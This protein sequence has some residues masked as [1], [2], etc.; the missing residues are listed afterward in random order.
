MLT[1]VP[2]QAQI[3]TSA[4]CERLSS[5][6]DE[7]ACLRNALDQSR[8]ALQGR[9]ERGE[10]TKP[11]QLKHA[12]ASVARPDLGSEQVADHAV[13][14][15]NKPAARSISA[16][17]VASSSGPQGLL[18][19]KLDNRQVWRQTEQAGIPLSL[20]RD[21]TYPVEIS[22]SGFGGYRMRFQNNGR[23]IVVRRLQ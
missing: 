4:D 18:T 22:G 23:V 13:H 19:L 14:P 20:R 12:A 9:K 8:A 1:G 3:A 2:G 5:Q 17:V 6:A 10:S 21:R 16:T 11:L 7:I 15:K